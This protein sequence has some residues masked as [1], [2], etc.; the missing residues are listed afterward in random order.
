MYSAED[1]RFYKISLIFLIALLMFSCLNYPF[2]FASEGTSPTYSN[3]ESWYFSLKYI[4]G[5]SFTLY[6]LSNMDRSPKFNI[7]VIVIV[8]FI[9][10]LSIV[11]VL[12]PIIYPSM[13]TE[14]NDMNLVKSFILFFIPILLLTNTKILIFE[15]ALFRSIDIV[16]PILLVMQTIAIYNFLATGRLPAQGYEAGLSR[17]ASFWDDPN[18]YGMFSAFTFIYY[19]L[20]QRYKTS[21]FIFISLLFTVSFS[22]FLTLFFG[23]FITMFK[24]KK[25]VVV[26]IILSFIAILSIYY[27]WDFLEVIYELKRGSIE[28]HGDFEI[29]FSLLPLISSPILHSESWLITVF[30]SYF[31]LSIGLVILFV[32]GMMSFYCRRTIDFT[33]LYILMFSIGCLMVPYVFSYPVNILFYALLAVYLRKKYIKGKQ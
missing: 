23:L 27:F 14:L 17:F 10:Y 5:I 18:G 8:L 2:K 6:M 16:T 21:A 20:T 28:S 31:P 32:L 33:L 11:N 26:N 9:V 3:P 4:I 19:F 7:F 30:F 29:I 25:I 1:I 15:K 13:K 12:N 22:A 24:T